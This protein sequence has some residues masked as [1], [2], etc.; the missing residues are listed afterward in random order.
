MSAQYD[1]ILNRNE[2]FTLYLEYQD[3]SGSRIDLV[4]NTAS[5]PL[6]YAKMMI[7]PYKKDT[8]AVVLL[9]SDPFQVLCGTTQAGISGGIKLNRNFGNTGG[10]TG[11]IFI[12]VNPLVTLTISPGKLFYDI[13]LIGR[14]GDVKGFSTKLLEGSVDVVQEITTNIEDQ[15]TAFS[16]NDEI[17]GGAFT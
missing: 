12:T 14:T 16:F 5:D 17:D 3:E 6:Y 2:N 9:K 11:G 13:F 4:G 15:F 8:Q 10:Y 7:K 1:L